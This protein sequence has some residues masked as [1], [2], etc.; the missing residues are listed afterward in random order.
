MVDLLSTSVVDSKALVDLLTTS[1]I[2]AEALVCVGILHQVRLQLHR[3]WCIR[4]TY[5]VVDAETLVDIGIL[6]CVVSVVFWSSDL[7][8][9]TY[10]IV[11]AEACVGV[12]V[13]GFIS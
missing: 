2:D 8:R 9:A 6:L 12:G 5:A 11:N 7:N 3:I 10:P 13:L 1:V 4:G